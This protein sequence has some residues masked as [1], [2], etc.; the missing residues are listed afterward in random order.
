MQIDM[1]GDT[2]HMKP[3]GKMEELMMK[4]DPKLY[5]KYATNEKWRTVLYVELEKA[6]YGTLQAAILFWQ[7]LASS[8]Q[9]WGVEIN[10]YDW[11]VANKTV[12]GK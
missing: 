3:E 4:L 9:E 1:E 2:V 7:N 10:T 8:L 5:G 11:C 6:L 12:N